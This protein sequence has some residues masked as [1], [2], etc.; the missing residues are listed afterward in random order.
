MGAFN[1]VGFVIFA[2]SAIFTRIIWNWAANHARG[3]GIFASLLHASSNAVSLALIPQLLPPP[4][5][6][7]L[8]LSG[9]V[10]LGITMVM[11]VGLVI[12]TRG[13]LGYR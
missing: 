9:L 5:P 6:D 12:L 1:P 4:A 8:A 13:K 7:Q 3:S 10:L 11:A 2:F